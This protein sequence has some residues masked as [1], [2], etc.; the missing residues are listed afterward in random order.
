MV[1]PGDGQRRYELL[2]VQGPHLHLVCHACGKVI[3]TDL[4]T[5]RPLVDR[6]QER[7]AFEADLDRLTIPGLCQECRTAF[8]G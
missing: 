5:A 2:G 7:Y 6:L 8:Q 3:S 4:E 1:D